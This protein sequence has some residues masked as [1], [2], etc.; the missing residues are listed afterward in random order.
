VVIGLV[1]V[2]V[3]SASIAVVTGPGT[4][5]GV[6]AIW[7]VVGVMSLP[8]VATISEDAIKRVPK[9]LKEASL[10]LGATRW[11]TMTKILIPV[12]TPGILASILLGMGN[13]IGET[14]AT[15]LIVGNGYLIPPIIAAGAIGDFTYFPPL[16]ALGFI[17]F[18]IIGALNL[19]IRA[20][21]K[22]RASGAPTKP[23]RGPIAV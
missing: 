14:M 7:I 17:L 3:I 15:Y 21:M 4:G 23:S 8:T 20:L 2:A 10:G 19:A 1:G 5:N 6:L 12:A 11:Q 22:G 18:F 9:D 16:Y 13:A